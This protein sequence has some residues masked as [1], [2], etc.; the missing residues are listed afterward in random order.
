MFSLYR[1]VN[2]GARKYQYGAVAYGTSSKMMFVDS[3]GTYADSGAAS[4]N[5]MSL[6]SGGV[7]GTV[8][9]IP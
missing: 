7:Y 1:F 5:V 3:G 9:V 4:S 2:G 6:D 8:Q